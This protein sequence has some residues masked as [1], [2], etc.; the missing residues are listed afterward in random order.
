MGNAVYLLTLFCCLLLGMI[1]G[2]YV[3]PTSWNKLVDRLLVFCLY[4]LLFFM[5]VKTGLIDNIT[6]QL[7]S[8]GL[9]ALGF[10]AAASA[11]SAA[12][13]I[14]IGVV[15]RK[16]RTASG[17]KEGDNRKK[18]ISEGQ[19]GMLSYLK[20]PAVLLLCAVTGGLL[21]A[22]TPLFAWYTDSITTILLYVL[23]FFVGV[24]M[25]QGEVDILGLL[26]NPVS[27]L[28]PVSTLAGTLLA[29]GALSLCIDLSLFKSLAVASGLGW[30][31]LSGVIISELGDPF[32]GSVSFLSNLF[33]E[34][35]A[36]LTIP[37]LAGFG[38][39]HAAVGV[40]GATSMDVTLPSVERHC[41]PSFVPISLAH[42]IVLSILV[43][44]LVP[45]FYSLG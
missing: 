6:S 14:L 19:P 34:S 15:L 43:P 13:I 36:F 29:A 35:I 30:Y 18:H 1:A 28:L 42:G 23:L 31:S 45:F 8:M 37:V 16:N 12:V 7:A 44:L 10:A 39:K 32:L 26:K 3:I 27:L 4:L 40:C 41:G 22:G 21:S 20:E 5:G 33:R 11:G 24:Q 38:R 9:L 25:V 2:N 17:V